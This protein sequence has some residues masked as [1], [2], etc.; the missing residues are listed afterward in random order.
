MVDHAAG[1]RE[2]GQARNERPRQRFAA[3][4]ER[5]ARQ[6]VGRHARVEQRLQ[7]ARHDLQHADVAAAHFLREQIRIERARGRQQVQRAARAQCAEQRRVAEVRGHG[8]HHRERRVRREREFVEHPLHVI[9]QCAVRHDDALRRAGRAGRIDQIGTLLRMRCDAHAGRMGERRVLRERVDVER[10]G[11][12]AGR[13]R[14]HIRDERPACAAIGGRGRQARGRLCRVEQHGQRAGLQR[15]EQADD[16][17]GRPLDTDDDGRFGR[18][19]L[20]LQRMRDAVRRVVEFGERQRRRRIG[21]RDAMRIGGRLPRE[22]G[23]DVR[24]FDTQ[25]TAVARLARRR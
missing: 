13:P 19:A 14:G 8:G 2:R 1:R 23:D 3:G 17:A 22:C 12:D 21:Q 18:H 11:V 15:A 10:L 7:M 16:E 20:Q 25:R 5:V 6:H 9:G 24:V 4:H